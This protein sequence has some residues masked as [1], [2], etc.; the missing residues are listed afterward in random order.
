MRV[1]GR[2]ACRA[3]TR[4]RTARRARPRR[5]RACARARSSGWTLCM[6]RSSP[7]SR[8][9]SAVSP[10]WRR[11]S[12]RRRASRRL[13]VDLPAAE[14]RE[15]LR[16]VEQVA[17]AAQRVAGAAGAVELDVGVHAGEQLAGR[18]RLD[19]IVVG[20][21]LEPFDRPVLARP[22]GDHDHRDVRGR[23]IGLQRPRAARSRRG[24][25]SSR[26]SRRAPAGS[27]GRARARPRRRARSGRGSG[28]RAATRCSR[29]CR[30][31]RRRPAP[32]GRSPSAGPAARRVLRVQPAQRL[33]HEPLG[34]TA[35]AV[36]MPSGATC[37]AGRC[38]APNGTARRT[39][40]PPARS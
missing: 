24:W 38:S 5:E 23:G 27:R 40:A 8:S 21:R 16:L 35:A 36:T 33:G 13:E 37:S 19:Q 7:P 12:S 28:S 34:E 32:R 22:R 14:P 30:R 4:A 31:C 10:T 29:A 11:Y 20:A 26:R 2:R 15:P 18:E 6:A 25:A 1:L 17:A 39:T 9:S 3:G